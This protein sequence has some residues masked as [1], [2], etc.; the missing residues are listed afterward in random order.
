MWMKSLGSHYKLVCVNQ[1]VGDMGHKLTPGQ[2][3]SNY[4]SDSL[5]GEENKLFSNSHYH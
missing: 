2:L 1:Q 5:L 4:C 3:L